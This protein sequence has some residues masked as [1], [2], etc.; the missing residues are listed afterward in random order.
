MILYSVGIQPVVQALLGGLVRDAVYRCKSLQT[1]TKAYA[2]LQPGTTMTFDKMRMLARLA[3]EGLRTSHM[4]QGNIGDCYFV[5]RWHAYKRSPFAPYLVAKMVEEKKDHWEVTF[6]G[7]KETIIVTKKEIFR[8][9]RIYRK[10]QDFFP[11]FKKFVSG[12]LLDQI[13]EKAFGRHLKR[14]ERKDKQKAAE[15]KVMRTENVMVG[16]W[17]STV[18]DLFLP[19]P[20]ASQIKISSMGNRTFRQSLL[21]REVT[22]LLIKI[23]RD[24][25]KHVIF[26]STPAGETPWYA[27]ARDDD[28]DEEKME[29]VYYMD[30]ERRFVTRHAYSVLQVNPDEKTVVVVNPHQTEKEH[31][32]SFERFFE[33][34]GTVE[35]AE[36]NFPK[37]NQLLGP[38]SGLDVAREKFGRLASHLPHEY[39][40][41][42][43]LPL[44]L[45]LGHYQLFIS[46]K[47]GRYYLRGDGL[48][49]DSQ[50]AFKPHEKIVF[51]RANIA[52]PSDASASVSHRHLEILF[53]DNGAAMITDIGSLN[54]TEAVLLKAPP[55][56]AQP[57]P[58][59]G[60]KAPSPLSPTV[61]TPVPP[62]DKFLTKGLEKLAPEQAY[63]FFPVIGKRVI[64]LGKKG[65]VVHVLGI[66]NQGFLELRMGDGKSLKLARGESLTLGRF[67]FPG[68][69]TVDSPHAT[70]RYGDDSRVAVTDLRSTYGS[71]IE[72]VIEAHSEI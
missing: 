49:R 31:V 36:L 27:W 18:D 9:G 29:K 15:Q 56:I 6:L 42:K 68:D 32:L 34:F 41:A 72:S 69:P 60:Q 45:R 3:P 53:E 13:L 14:H 1:G 66:D 67:D 4:R 17:A 39:Q 58:N 50:K 61:V 55:A 23:A 19:A 20:Y 24:P 51:G 2:G 52:E 5:S 8:G 12:S 70:I 10:K 28:E 57:A 37:L 64:H 63:A 43:G 22:D 48:S 65:A 54:G 25:G 30:A 21:T 35:V 40:V 7:G 62:R 59:E 16:G 46:F 47:D 44:T 11:S 38:I 71:K 33:L 26:A